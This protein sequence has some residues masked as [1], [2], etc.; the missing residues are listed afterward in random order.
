M[1]RH[2]AIGW[3]WHD[4][5]RDFIYRDFIYLDIDRVQS[6]L[7]QLR[8]GLLTE[9]M[10]GKTKDLTGKASAEA[11]IL[12]GFLPVG[13]NLSGTYRVSYQSSKVLHDYA[14]TAALD[15][16]KEARLVL[17]VDD[18]KRDE[19]PIPDASFVLVRGT[20]SILDYA[21]LKQIVENE[22]VISKIFSLDKNRWEAKQGKDKLG[23]KR[24]NKT[25]TV[26]N[27]MKHFIDL[28]LGDVVQIRISRGQLLFVGTINRQFL[29]ES[30]RDFIFKYGG[31][32]Q[33]GWVM[34]AQVGQVTAPIDKVQALNQFL[35]S[36]SA[37]E[38]ANFGSAT[39]VMNLIV[40]A[41]NKM[42]EL[43]ASVSYPA[44][45]VTPIALYREIRPLN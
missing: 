32:P 27:L 45:A 29:R 23:T 20:A 12:A 43:M 26:F 21:L 19:V 31:H 7:A 5:D 42:Q 40:E 8:Q 14:F 1:N 37:T 41:V 35:A 4:L 36:L 28:F 30:T 39:D 11:R 17:E 38:T 13:A 16:L 10:S 25:V 34:L 33:D 18:W 3:G 22:Q 6:I 2:R 44:I 15:A 24:D 9:V